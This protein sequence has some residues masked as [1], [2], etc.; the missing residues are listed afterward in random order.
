ME[1]RCKIVNNKIFKLAVAGNQSK[2]HSERGRILV[3]NDVSE[4]DPLHLLKTI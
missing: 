2:A 1:I 3:R 4:I